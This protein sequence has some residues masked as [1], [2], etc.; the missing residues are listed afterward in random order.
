M[1]NLA[2]ANTPIVNLALPNIVALVIGTDLNDWAAVAGS[3]AT[4]RA[5]VPIDDT[6][7]T[8]FDRM[9]YPWRSAPRL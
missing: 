1:A 5:T 7:P 3:A 6:K 4:N 2:L 9:I 8:T